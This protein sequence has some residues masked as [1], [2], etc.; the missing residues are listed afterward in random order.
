MKVTFQEGHLEF[1]IETI[2][3]LLFF[4]FFFFCFF[5]VFLFFCF[6]FLIYNDP[7][8]SY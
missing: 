7:D 2:V 3:F 4:F 8:T 5:F 6:S 1:P